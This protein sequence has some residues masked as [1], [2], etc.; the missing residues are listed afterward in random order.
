MAKKPS[1]EEII[2]QC[3]TKGQKVK[4]IESDAQNTFEEAMNNALRQGWELLPETYRI[5]DLADGEGNF[6]FCSYSIIAVKNT[7]AR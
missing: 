1:K 7:S 6:A 2:M 3:I 4:I 5:N